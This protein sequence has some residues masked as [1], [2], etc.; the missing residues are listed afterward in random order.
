MTTTSQDEATTTSNHGGWLNHVKKYREEH[1]VSFK[2][3]LVKASETYTKQEKRMKKQSGDYKPNPWMKHI[4]KFKE[5]NPDWKETLSYKQV[6]VRCK[7]T[8][9]KPSADT[10]SE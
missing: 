5:E 9:V 7:E 2:V 8:Y 6:L 3:A 1:G 10:S 4:L